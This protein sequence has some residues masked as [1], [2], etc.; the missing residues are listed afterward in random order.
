MGYIKDFIKKTYNICDEQ[1]QTGGGFNFSYEDG[2]LITDK[3]AKYKKFKLTPNDIKNIE[4][5]EQHIMP[6]INLDG[7]RCGVNLKVDAK[8]ISMGGFG[9]LFKFNCKTANSRSY[10]LKISIPSQLNTPDDWKMY[11]GEHFILNKF[12][13][14]KEDENNGK[15]LPKYYGYIDLTG[16]NPE[17]PNKLVMT[18][19][20]F[21]IN[22]AEIE[23]TLLFPGHCII[24][25]QEWLDGDL[26]EPLTF[27]TPMD[28]FLMMISLSFSLKQL[29]DE[30]LV[31]CDIKGSNL[32]KKDLPDKDF[33]ET[34]FSNSF[35][36]IKRCIYKVIDLGGVRTDGDSIMSYTPSFLEPEKMIFINDKKQL[37]E[38]FEN[39]QKTGASNKILN[40][41]LAKLKNVPDAMASSSQDV[42]ALGMAIIETLG[43]CENGSSH[44][45]AW[46]STKNIN[47]EK[48]DYSRWNDIINETY[49]N[50]KFKTPTFIKEEYVE[51][52]NKMINSLSAHIKNFLRNMMSEKDERFSIRKLIS[53]MGHFIQ[54]HPMAAIIIWEI[55]GCRFD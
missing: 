15:L 16:M 36:E 19:G 1:K 50:I 2:S 26:M 49:D 23:D 48:Y 14:E 52:Y 13:N 22:V 24:F 18:D 54:T 51:N 30:N 6:N 53:Y 11:Y 45:G 35:T 4:V 5:F 27:N 33:K 31:H 41:T 8:E 7:S 3:P 37:L 21:D 40:A 34:E 44:K 17:H 47:L 20:L 42:Y 38:E 39:L 12:G 32:M 9:I 25:L 55:Y 46:L 43:L 28:I 10:S 29:H